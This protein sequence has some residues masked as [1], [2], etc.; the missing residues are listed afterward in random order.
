MNI[1]PKIYDCFLYNDEEELLEIRLRLLDK[2]IHRFVIVCSKE[3]F[4]GRKKD[5]FFPLKNSI[6]ES[7]LSRIDLIVID[8]LPGK[9]PW[10]KESY[11]RNRLAS[12][13]DGLSPD[14]ICIISDVDE[15][16]R[17]SV[18]SSLRTCRNLTGVKALGLDYFNF[19]FNYQMLH[20]LQ[21]TWIGPTI[22]RYREYNNTAGDA[23]YP[24]V[25]TY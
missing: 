24:L 18:I 22:S 12:S 19:K 1:I 10:Q 6:V 14:D 23:Q 20:G 9:T 17:P 25:S 4:T 3:T 5:K 7:Y 16:P 2:S 21:A 13:L 11:S 8:K 15:I